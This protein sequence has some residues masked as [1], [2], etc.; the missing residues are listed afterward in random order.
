MATFRL[1]KIDID[2]AVVLN[3]PAAADATLAKGKLTVKNEAGVNSLIFKV[4]A[5]G[6]GFTKTAY[7][8]GVLSVKTVT[9]PTPVSNSIYSITIALPNRLD[10]ALVGKESNAVVALRTYTVSTDA[11]ATATELKNAFVAAINADPNAGVVAASTGASTFSIKMSDVNSG[12]TTIT[13]PS[14]FSLAVGTAYTAPSGTP[15]EVALYDTTGLANGEYTKWVITYRKA[16]PHYAVSQKKVIK[17]AVT[18]VYAE[19]NAANF[20]AFV[21][22]IDDILNGVVDDTDAASV[23]LGLAKYLA[24]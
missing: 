1:P 11:S 23:A 5:D 4:L 21:T 15:S 18:I 12:D 3:T 16:I 13:L 2:S 24:L 7:S 17:D 8:A 10:F 19:E 14:G 20:A 6:I 9:V 22:A